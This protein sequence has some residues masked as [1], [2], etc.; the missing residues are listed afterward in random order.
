MM[1][2]HSFRRLEEVEK[3]LQQ[4]GSSH[5]AAV[6]TLCSLKQLLPASSSYPHREA[7]I[8][9]FSQPELHEALLGAEP[10]FASL[11]PCRV[12]A[13]EDAGG[14][15][16]EAVSP[17]DFCGLL[18]RP[19]LE[20]TAGLLEASLR[21]TLEEASRP[22]TATAAAAPARPG[23]R[24]FLGATEDQVNMQGTVPQRIDNRG[25]KV[26]DLAGTGRHDAPGG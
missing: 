11:L 16:L 15:T 6:R 18:A 3:A 1:Q 14:V 5:R 4:A 13:W 23:S 12:V 9:S 2:V 24:Y 25:T 10:R 8:Y 21:A 26:E 22:R 17:R 20:H 7:T 19:D